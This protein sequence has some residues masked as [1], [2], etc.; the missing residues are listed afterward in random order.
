M[1]VEITNIVA[2]FGNYYINEGQN[3]SRLLSNIRQKSVTPSFAKPLIVDS[4]VYRFSNVTLGEIVQQFQKEF[5]PKGDVAFEP[6]EIRLRNLKIDLSLYP[7]DVK[8]SWLGFL[9]SIEEQERKN[10]P[11][12][13]Y[14]LET[15]VVPQIPQDMETKA[16]FKGVY[17]PVVSGTP[18]TAAGS[19]DGV[20]KLLDAGVVG[21]MNAVALSAA[22]STA[23]IFDS[24]EE[25]VDNF[26]SELSGTKMR[27]Y[28]SPSWV[29]AYFRDKRNSH[30][31][32][33]NY[34]ISGI[35]IVDFMPNVEI[36]ALPSME[37]EDYIWAT[38][39]DNFLYLR[40]SGSMQTPKVEEAKRGV[41]LMLDWYEGIGFGYD[42]LVYVYKP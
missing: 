8:S 22:L 4:D 38:P 9:G 20:K 18:G 3:M 15:E 10:W 11:I 23:N 28:M 30:G 26:A 41:F 1:A 16:Y 40:K 27:V 5:T 39:V 14:L 7:D 13:R 21:N 2:E 31:G 24:V 29:R 17:V 34:S 12:T 42:Q 36:V 33:A 35:N 32:D 19:M 25:F 37:G 6:N